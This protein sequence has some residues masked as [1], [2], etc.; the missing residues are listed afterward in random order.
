MKKIFLALLL[1]L[2]S[3]QG[4]QAAIA[5]G[6]TGQSATGAFQNFSTITVSPAT[7]GSTFVLVGWAG[8]SAAGAVTDSTGANSGKWAAAASGVPTFATYQFMNVWVCQ[9]CTGASGMVV[10]WTP[11]SGAYL[12]T[13][14]VEITGAA[15][16]SLDQTSSAG[17]SPN[18]QSATFTAPSVTTTHAAELVLGITGAAASASITV[19]ATSG[20]KILQ[21]QDTTNNLSVTTSDQ[22]VSSTG[23]YSPTFSS[24][25]SVYYG[26]LTLSFIQAGG[27]GSCTNAGYNTAT[28]GFSVPTSGSGHFWQSGGTNG[29]VNC[30]SNS[31]WKASGAFGVN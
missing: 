27:G 29:S 11:A 14:F 31:Y 26:A 20:T 9:N 12:P 8:T 23:T 10:T 6:V 28:G 22:I 16:T 17:G 24:T 5:V 25:A 13:Q 3:S 18:S 30:S 21:T 15:A 7:S 1:A 4:A 19:S 2:F